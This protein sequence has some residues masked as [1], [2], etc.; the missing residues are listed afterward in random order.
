MTPRNWSS[1]APLIDPRGVIEERL[2]CVTVLRRWLLY[3]LLLHFLLILDNYFI[4]LN[5]FEIVTRRSERSCM[6]YKWP[7]K[8]TEPPSTARPFL[9]DHGL[10]S[11]SITSN[12]LLSGSFPSLEFALARLCQS[13]C[14]L[15]QFTFRLAV[16][17]YQ[18]GCWHF[19]SFQLSLYFKIISIP[20]YGMNSWIIGLQSIQQRPCPRTQAWQTKFPTEH[21]VGPAWRC[22]RQQGSPVLSWKGES[23][24]SDPIY[25]ADHLS[26]SLTYY[27]PGLPWDNS[28]LLTCTAQSERLVAQKSEWSGGQSLSLF[29]YFHD[30]WLCY[31]RRVTRP[32]GNSGVVKA[33]F[34]SNLPP[35]AFGASVRI[36]CPF[37]TPL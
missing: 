33:K 2:H 5:L 36:V 16:S 14:N 21:L 18:T 23:P 11:V 8:Q 9:H 28:A 26:S 4:I 25:L 24:P 15:P 29:T 35:H 32:H 13:I 27:L 20:T 30:Y 10:Y 1:I 22:K 31:D 17:L 34:S 3:V 37:I 7:N 12:Q 19:V 6:N